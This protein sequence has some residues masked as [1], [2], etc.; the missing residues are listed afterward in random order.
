MLSFW[1]DGCCG[2][3]GWDWVGLEWDWSGTGWDTWNWW[4][5]WVSGAV[6]PALDGV[7]DTVLLVVLR[8]GERHA[9]FLLVAVLVGEDDH[10]VLAR[11]I[12]LQLVGQAVEGVLVGDGAL[13]GGDHDEELVVGDMCGELWQFV[14]M[15]HAGEFCAYR[16]VA[17]VDIFIDERQ[18]LLASVEL[19][20][21]VEL[22]GQA[23]EAF[24]PAVESWFELR[25]AGHG[26]T[27]AAQGVQRLYESHEHNL[28]VQAIVETLYEVAPELSVL[29]GVDM[30]A[31]DD[32]RAGR[33]AESVL[34]AVGD[35]GGQSY[36]R[37]QPYLRGTGLLL[38]LFQEMQSLFSVIVSL[39][40]VVDHVKGYRQLVGLTIA[41]EECQVE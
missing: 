32:L 14:P 1:G 21:A 23:A 8:L 27:Y 34:D 25:T 2:G 3:T 18:R 6:K 7:V 41:Y 33:L 39:L 40:V 5:L 10:E 29:V 26:D 20:S 15:L 19:C 17:A 36:L 22:T 30:H 4:V 38:Q 9:V 11:E 12:L 13:T 28:A 16:M 31:H 24:E 35:V 37:H